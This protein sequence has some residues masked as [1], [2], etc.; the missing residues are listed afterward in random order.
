MNHVLR[1][2][3]AF[4]Y[5]YIFE[6]GFNIEW[7]RKKSERSRAVRKRGSVGRVA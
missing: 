3:V 6:S 7:L 4:F 2:L 5:Y 1:V